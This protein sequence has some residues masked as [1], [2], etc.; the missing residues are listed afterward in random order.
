MKRFTLLLLCAL[1]GIGA[2][3]QNSVSG[4]VTDSHGQPLP[5]VGVL[6]K[7][8][9]KG[10]VTDLSGRYQ[11]TVSEGDILEFSQLG[12]KSR[13]EAVK[14]R[15]II[16]VSLAEDTETLDEVV[17]IGYGVQKKKLLTGANLSVSGDKIAKQSTTDVL[18]ALQSL[19]PGVN[20][21]QSSGQVGEDYKVNIRGLGTT[22]AS[23]PLYIVDGVPGGNLSALNPSDI[24][25]IDVLKD[26]ASAAIYGSRAANGVILITT[27]QAKQSSDGTKVSV[28][29]DGY[30][31][32]QNLNTN[33]VT[34]LDGKQYMEILNKAL[35]SNNEQPLDFAGL[36]PE[37]YDKIQKGQ[38]KGTNWLKESMVKNAPMQ[39]HAVNLAIGSDRST[40]SMGF[41]YLGQEG[42]LGYP[43]TPQFRRIT[44]R[45]NS[46]HV[47]WRHNGRDIIRFGENITYTNRSKSGIQ[48]GDN[49]SNNVR[50]LLTAC[51]LLPAYNDEGDPYILKDMN[52]HNWA[53]DT[54][55]DNPLARIKYKNGTSESTGNRLQSNFFLEV[56]PV[57]GL[58]IK[59]NAGFHYNQTNYRRYVPVY[60]LSTDTNSTEDKITQ[61][62]SYS[63]RW[64]VENT[65][66]YANTFG[67]HSID[68]LVGQSLEKWGYGSSVEATNINSLFP[69]S[70]KNAYIDNTQGITPGK[71]E[72]KGAPNTR[73]ALSS[74]FGR[75]NYNYKEKYMASVVFRA[76]GSSNFARGHRWGYFPS[77]SAGWVMT[78]EPWMAPARKVMNFFKIRGSW[79]QNGN[80][81]IKNFQYLA[82]I[83]YDDTSK[84]Y[85]TDK[86]SGSTGFYPNIL[87]NEDVTWER[88]EQLDFGFDSR[89]FNDRLS[90]S[91]DWYR[92][93]TKDW[94]VVAP[95]L[96]SYG[97]GAPY[98]N[99]GD[100]R[101]SGV[102]LSINWSDYS[103]KFGYSIGV[104]LAHNR[105][106]VT[107]IANQ[108]GIIHGPTKV[109]AESTAEVYRA[110][111]GY[112]LGYF[113]GFKTG[114]VFQSQ[115]QIDKFLADGGHTLQKN[116]KP[117][118]LIFVDTTGEGDFNDADKVMIGNPHPDVNLGLNIALSYAGFD[119]AINGYGAF[120][121][122]IMKCYRHFSNK[123]NNNYT[124][125]VYTK[126]WTGEGS[127]NKYPIFEHGKSDN[128]TNISDMYVE[129]GDYFKI[130][131]I[132]LGYDFA[133]LYKN[134]GLK[135]L[136][137]FVT[138]K[139]CITMTKYSGMDPEVGYGLNDTWASGIDIGYYPSSRAFL[140]GLSLT[141]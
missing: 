41:S 117:G 6:L 47:L 106:K 113:W 140:V 45:I 103:H 136:R 16:D 90:I 18:G 78:N 68:V 127:T 5:S 109:L 7:G 88:S 22:G 87:P 54:M 21:V 63:M 124:T 42:T 91:F 76:D 133:R 92:K 79:G 48:I 17:L 119:L 95:Q 72:V 105:N 81:D 14:G 66:N 126:Y 50:D 11:I 131:N 34:P 15:S 84:Y 100:V 70:F 97:T 123:P 60:E 39:S 116:P 96:L 98:I 108:E 43:S 10:V 125:D 82:T 27:K 9:T 107:R 93:M 137:L 58:T 35:E 36:I 46:A 51:P 111:V 44:A 56:K 37:Y 104:N 121:Q 57:K 101:N 62:Q 130:S 102:E 77:V 4:T 120:G 129:N 114:G 49:Y 61:K 32:F 138:A 12:F 19:A 24:E 13:T 94:L 3:A 26:A 80:A 64:S 71:T 132:T 67:D 65:V 115:D 85:F 83:A 141:F 122:Q 40:Y 110:Q 86:D 33:G 118:D 139:N 2:F 52:E 23:E 89:F 112:P 38:W 74:F 30:V 28:T 59:S 55:I 69:D 134:K 73:G 31:G 25:S 20:I 53:F 135:Q 8:T 75:V 1:I 128:F 99:G 29:Y